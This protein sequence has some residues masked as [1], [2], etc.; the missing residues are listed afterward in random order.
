MRLSEALTLAEQTRSNGHY[1]EAEALYNLILQASPAN[2]TAMH[3]LS[4]AL[5]QQGQAHNDAHQ[6]AKYYCRAI[7]A[8][9]K[10]IKSR[11]LLGMSYSSLGRIEEATDVYYQWLQKE[12]GNPIAEH[13][14]A[15]CSG[16]NIPERA[17]NSYIETTFDGFSSDF[18]EH[19]TGNL[20]YTVPQL[21]GDL[22]TRNVI[23]QG[24]L[25]TLDAGCGTGLCGAVLAPYSARLTGVD[26]SSGMLAAAQNIELYDAL[27]KE[28]IS[29]FLFKN[30]HS[31]DMVVMAD[32]L[33]YFGSLERIFSATSHALNTGGLFIFSVENNREYEQKTDNQLNYNGRYSHKES[34]VL[35]TLKNNGF[36][37][38][39]MA[40][41]TLRMEL[42]SPVGGML[43]MA[44]KDSPHTAS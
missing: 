14:Y 40:T 28:E 15:A 42:G 25:H 1:A 30:H 5:C 33:I 36:S 24:N 29:D 16:N 21:I 32:T 31:F 6:A 38:L 18:D 3:G 13:F 9:Q 17:S 8:N 22:L 4:I 41:H 37:I 27:I 12:P 19:L 11:M 7:I 26:L 10:N 20:S 35:D 2:A 23:Q 34:Y 44:V 39:S 43:V